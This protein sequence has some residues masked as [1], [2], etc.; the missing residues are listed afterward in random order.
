MGQARSNLAWWTA[1]LLTIVIAVVYGGA[2][3]VPFIFDDFNSIQTNE[4]IVSLWP[5]WSAEPPFGPEL[6]A[7]FPEHSRAASLGGCRPV[8]AWH[9]AWPL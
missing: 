4:T 1:A 7:A 8:R 3:D 2:V 9:A 6:T 5:L